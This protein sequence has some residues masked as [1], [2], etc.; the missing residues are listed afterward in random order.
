LSAIALF[1]RLSAS[2]TS[3]SLGAV[4]VLIVGSLQIHPDDRHLV[5]A[6]G[7]RALENRIDLANSLLSYRQPAYLVVPVLIQE[8]GRL[9]SRHDLELELTGDGE[10]PM[11]MNI[12]Y[13]IIRE[14]ER[15]RLKPGDPLPGT[16][17]L[18][19]SLK[20][21]RNTVDAAYQ[22]LT[23]QGWLV[24]RPSRGTFVAND[25]P[26]PAGGET[27]PPTLRAPLDPVGPRHGTSKAA[28]FGRRT[29]RTAHAGHLAGKGVPNCADV[30]GLRRRRRLRRPS[31][32]HQA[33]HGPVKLSH[34]RAGANRLGE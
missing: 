21:H 4:I 32:Y 14:I 6:I 1:I 18:S 8:I 23:M 7:H 3:S 15:G 27:L 24:A 16:R 31:W 19:T 9:G 20:V 12:A 11:F 30:A 10:R 17:A 26:E 25:L 33:A 29:G 34:L 28:R 2:F 5:S 22:E 13:S